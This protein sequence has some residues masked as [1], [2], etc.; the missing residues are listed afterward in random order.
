[1]NHATTL[2]AALLGSGLLSTTLTF[3]FSR[4]RH[5]RHVDALE[6][7]INE[8][9]LLRS[10]EKT[11]ELEPTVTN[12]Q[13]R[14]LAVAIAART[15]INAAM[16]AR[17]IPRDNFRLLILAPLGLFVFFG[18]LLLLIASIGN[19]IAS[20]ETI[21]TAWSIVIALIS[22][23]MSCI[24]AVMFGV[25]WKSEI[26]QDVMRAEVQRSM[27]MGDTPSAHSPHSYAK[28]YSWLPGMEPTYRRRHVIALRADIRQAFR[29]FIMNVKEPSS[30]TNKK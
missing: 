11:A 5:D 4:W 20:S 6:T 19:A 17:L 30:N 7:W 23:L 12:D 26:Y 8:A 2:I 24:G 10:L 21:D 22:V 13:S 1:M 29:H 15:Q 28:K 25:G 18:S 3:I 14:N 9:K 16:A 27:E